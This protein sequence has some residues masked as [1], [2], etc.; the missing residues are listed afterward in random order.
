MDLDDDG[1]LDI[2]TNDFND[3][4]QVLINSLSTV[5]PPHY[6]QVRLVGSASNRDGLGARVQVK[7]GGV[8]QTRYHDGKSGY[9][10][11]SALPL[12]FGLGEA[13]TIDRIEVNWPSGKTQVIENPGKANRLLT[14]TEP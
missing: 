14:L 13:D 8:V 12:Y 3:E 1:D 10:A 6:I 9:L 2:V 7:T 4:P 11:Q 5:R